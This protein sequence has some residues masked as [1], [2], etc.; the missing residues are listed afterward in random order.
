MARPR[1]LVLA[2]SLAWA[3]A[4]CSPSHADD[5]SLREL[6]ALPGQSPVV[7]SVASSENGYVAVGTAGGDSR[8]AAWRSADGATWSEVVLE[9]PKDL[10]GRIAPLTQVAVHDGTVATLGVTSGGSHG[11]P[12]Y[13]TW[14]GP[15]GGP[16]VQTLQPFA[17][18]GGLEAISVGQLAEWQNGFAIAG[19]WD[20]GEDGGGPGAALWHSADGAAW[21]RDDSD[22]ALA[23]DAGGQVGAA[24]AAGSAAGLVVAGDRLT[25]GSGSA[26]SVA[27][28]WLVEPSGIARRIDL[29]DDPGNPSRAACAGEECVAVGTRSADGDLAYAVWWGRPDRWNEA[30]DGPTGVA[31]TGA[32]QS[33]VLTSDHTAYVVVGRTTASLWRGDPDGWE[34]LSL[35]AGTTSARLA[36]SGDGVIAVL[37]TEGTATAY[38]VEE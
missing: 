3:C 35:P 13:A 2:L 8:P 23:S 25:T 21:T 28:F 4:A 27:Q 36:A 30:A 7:L 5:A 10:Y 31:E 34:E 19:R 37:T 29:P 17:L 6:G 22:A 24:A 32:I 15:A 33:L 38:A 14:S 12:R 16:L 26:S 9:Q 18:F 20:R 11:N 1:V